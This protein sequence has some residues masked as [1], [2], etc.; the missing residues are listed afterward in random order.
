MKC[1]FWIII[2]WWL[3]YLTLGQTVKD[4]VS[5]L[6]GKSPMKF[7]ENI[8][9]FHSLEPASPKWRFEPTPQKV[10]LLFWLIIFKITNS[11]TAW[12]DQVTL[13]SMSVVESVCSGQWR[14]KMNVVG[15]NAPWWNTKP[16]L[17]QCVCCC[18]WVWRWSLDIRFVS[19]SHL[20][21][22]A[23]VR[24]SGRA[25][26]ACMQAHI[27]THVHTPACLLS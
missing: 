14:R 13:Q 21:V 3:F 10:G 8:G 16:G 24:T 12:Q 6:R 23:Y 20:S 22:S 7:L 5:C 4:Y 17:I 19:S 26:Q 1:A 9:Q 25:G 2:L 11:V 18:W 15:L 27:R